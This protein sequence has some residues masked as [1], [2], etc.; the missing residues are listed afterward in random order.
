MSGKSFPRDIQTYPAISQ[1]LHWLMVVVIVA[2]L[3]IGWGL[4]LI[5]GEIKP[6]ILLIHTSLGVGIFGLFFVRLINR[7]MAPPPPLVQELSPL[8]KLAAESAHVALYVFMLVMPLSG[9]MLVSAMGRPPVLFGLIPLPA[10][11]PKTTALV[12]LLREIHGNSALFLVGFILAHAGAAFYHHFIRKDETL[13]R[14]LPKRF[15]V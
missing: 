3:T 13:L 15:H 8:V 1:I 12:P 9:W 11:F 4:D 2:L 14:M 5:H 6:L 7:M 10:L